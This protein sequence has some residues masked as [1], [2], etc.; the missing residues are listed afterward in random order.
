VTAVG[1]ARRSGDGVRRYDHGSDL[2]CADHAASLDRREEKNWQ[3]E[4]ERER[5]WERWLGS[6]ARTFEQR[7]D[8][9]SDFYESL[10]EMGRTVYDHGMGLSE[11]RK[12]DSH[13]R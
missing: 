13:R 4:R 12:S 11:S 3:R 7:R 1:A 5:E 8:A 6:A 9:Y 2:R 10:C